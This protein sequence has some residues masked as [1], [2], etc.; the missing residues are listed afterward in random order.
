MNKTF[1]RGA[2]GNASVFSVT[3]TLTALAAGAS[4]VLQE[5]I[6]LG[7]EITGIRHVNGNL[8]SNTGIKVETV[9][10]NGDKHTLLDVTG[11]KAAD[12]KPIKPVYL[13]GDDHPSLVLT[14]DGTAAAS[15]EVT[16]Q[17]EYVFKGY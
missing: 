2:Q 9:Y 13:D 16:I 5:S 7:T 14:N 11:S 15:G 4:L 1:Y 12:S 8:G 3:V 6:P 17:L 10:D